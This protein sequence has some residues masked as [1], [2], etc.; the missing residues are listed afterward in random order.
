MSTK[1]KAKNI[2]DYLKR[3]PDG[4]YSGF[5]PADVAN[6]MIQEAMLGGTAAAV[7]SLRRK[8]AEK[9]FVWENNKESEARSDTE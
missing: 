8:D 2:K 5:V 1:R 3:N 7:E 9:G 4:S 6:R